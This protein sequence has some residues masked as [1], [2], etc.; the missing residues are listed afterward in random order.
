M[1]N[2]QNTAQQLANWAAQLDTRQLSDAVREEAIRCLVDT[3]GVSIAGVE[4]ATTRVSHQLAFDNYANG[5]CWV[6]GSPATLS[7][8][9]AAF[10]NGVAAHVLDFDDVSY[11]GMVHASAVVWPAV[12]AAGE[13]VN[14]SGEQVMLAFIAG[15][16]AEYAL[17]R[18]M[19]HDLFWRGWWTTGLLRSIGAAIGVA[20]VMNL[21]A[22]TI[23]EAIA[24]AACQATGPYVLVGSPVKAYASG[25]AAEV[26]VQAAMAAQAGLCGP[27]ESFE[28]PNGFI[29]M[30]G[31]QQFIPEEIQMLGSRYVLETSRV[32]FKQYPVCSAGQSSVEALENLLSRS[33]LAGNDIAEIRCEVTSEVA[34]Y[35]AVTEV[36]TVSEAQFCLPF[37]LACMLC[38]G[39]LTI[40][41]LSKQTI[42]NPDVIDAMNKVTVIYSDKLDQLCKQQDDH[43]LAAS[44]NVVTKDGK[45]AS[46]FI[47]A[48]TG[49]ALNPMTTEQLDKKFMQCLLTRS[50][51]TLARQ[52]L[53]RIKSIDE[54]ENIRTLFI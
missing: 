15:V 27:E 26:G 12:L 23:K 25:R 24:I 5:P 41:Q 54:L 16:E 11:E 13:S 10:C 9:G 33:G 28:H 43:Q 8:S 17:G 32:A 1:N 29:A 38:F 37:C 50:D 20:K 3:I 44:L 36:S 34:H 30:Y 49:L 39:E 45:S 35:M 40:R 6:A 47:A 46:E 42:D 7:A 19:T 18:A 14:A 31:N 22:D 53:Q 48:P 21:D 51:T 4:H 52:Q 2:N